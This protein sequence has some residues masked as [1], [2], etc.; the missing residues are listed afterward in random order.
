MIIALDRC[1]RG[2]SNQSTLAEIRAQGIEVYSI[3]NLFDIIE[4]LQATD[5]KQ[6]VAQLEKY[7]ELY[8][9]TQ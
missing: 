3:I 9:T 6:S 4:Y 1:E 8:G 7:Q 5:Q 2:Q